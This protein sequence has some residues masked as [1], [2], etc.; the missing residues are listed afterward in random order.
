MENI[1]DFA[2]AKSARTPHAT[3]DAK[4]LDCKHEWVATAPVGVVRLDCPECGS[5]RGQ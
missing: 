5:T 2:A 4:C 1:V 3:G